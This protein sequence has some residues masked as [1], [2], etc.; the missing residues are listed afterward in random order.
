M[1]AFTSHVVHNHGN[2]TPFQF[3]NVCTIFALKVEV[4]DATIDGRETSSQHHLNAVHTMQKFI[5]SCAL[6]AVNAFSG[7]QFVR[8]QPHI[9]QTHRSHNHA[10]LTQLKHRKALKACINHHAMHHQVRAC[11]NKCAYT[12]QN[13]GI[14]QGNEQFCSSHTMFFSPAFYH[15]S[16][17]NHHR[18]VIQKS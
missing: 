4:D 2:T 3:K 15:R 16:K 5:R 14:R 13:G 8:E 10:H 11:T 17:N 1:K 7:Q 6:I 9:K 12:S 18:R